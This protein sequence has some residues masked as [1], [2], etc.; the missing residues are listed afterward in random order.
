METIELHNKQKGNIAEAI[1]EMAASPFITSQV[2]KYL[3]N[4]TGRDKGLKLPPV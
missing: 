1:V 4:P 3:R 2:P